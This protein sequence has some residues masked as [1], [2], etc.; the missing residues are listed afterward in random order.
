M[1][2]KLDIVIDDPRVMAEMAKM[3]PDDLENL[4][5]FARFENTVMQAVTKRLGRPFTEEEWS[6]FSGIFVNEL[7]GGNIH[8][9][10]LRRAVVKRFFKAH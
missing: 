4:I 5:W 3:S 1:E 10:P 7:E 6:K 9:R 8:E 2:R